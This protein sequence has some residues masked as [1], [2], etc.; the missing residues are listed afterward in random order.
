MM[1]KFLVVAYLVLSLSTLLTASAWFTW[2]S[3]CQ[4]VALLPEGVSYGGMCAGDGVQFFG[5]FGFFVILT[6]VY[7]AITWLLLKLL[8]LKLTKK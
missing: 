6:A 2:S 4:Y 8:G 7:L 5:L 1:R 3:S